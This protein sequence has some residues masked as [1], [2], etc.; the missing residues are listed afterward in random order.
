MT[1]RSLIFKELR[2][3]KSDL[4]ACCLTVALGVAL[5]VAVRTVTV[6]ARNTLRTQMHQLGANLLVVPQAGAVRDYY[7]ADL[8]PEDM[9]ED[10]A[11]RLS[12]SALSAKVHNMAAKLSTRVRLGNADAILTG[13]LPKEELRHRPRWRLEKTFL[14][15][16]SNGDSGRAPPAAEGH[17]EHPE[18]HPPDEDPGPVTRLTLDALGPSRV[19][20]G[21]E[22]ARLTG[23]GPGDTL[24]IRG[25]DF[26]VERILEHTG[27]VDDV[28]VYAHL[29]TVQDILG[30]RGRINAIE[31]V[32]CGCRTDLGEMGRDI[33]TLLP[34]TRAVTIRH[35]AETQKGV[36]HTAEGFAVALLLIAVLLGGATIGNYVAENVRERRRE[37]GTLL[38]LGASPGWMARLF[39][40][41]AVLVGVVGSVAGYCIG[42]TLAAYLG[43]HIWPV[44]VRPLPSLLAWVVPLAVLLTV[45][46]SA[47]PVRGALT[48]DPVTLLEAE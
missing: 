36:I 18:V 1:C 14:S 11:H 46:F 31:I 47:L 27:T 5:I 44:D 7:L 33:E 15:G 3:R 32:G 4:V 39:L 30:K 38:A 26:Q 21:A 19:L 20:L 13:V 35:I 41:K 45:G 40:G 22:I 8:I 48:L 42:A 29:H 37:L 43:P 34:G 10:Y 16:D 25:R 6:S 28:R 12:A 23:A 9:S 24:S 2:R 17:R